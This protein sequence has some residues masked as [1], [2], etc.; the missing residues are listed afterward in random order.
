MIKKSFF[1]DEKSVIFLFING[2]HHVYHLIMPALRFVA[3]KNE[4]ETL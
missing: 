4:I 2:P 3:L 1:P